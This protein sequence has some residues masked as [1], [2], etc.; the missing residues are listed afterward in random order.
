[1]GHTGESSRRN[2]VER[3]A[4]VAETG[5]LI[6]RSRAGSQNIPPTEGPIVS[7]ITTAIKDSDSKV[8]AHAESR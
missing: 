5:T 1:M 6:P 2:S 7:G 3:G 4:R 8:S